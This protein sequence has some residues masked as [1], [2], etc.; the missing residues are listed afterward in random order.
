MKVIE[1]TDSVIKSNPTMA[2]Q[3]AQAAI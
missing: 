2:Q 3:I 1:G